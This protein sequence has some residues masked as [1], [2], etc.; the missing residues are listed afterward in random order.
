MKKTI[1]I[2]IPSLDEL[3]AQAK[4]NIKAKEEKAQ[5]FKEIA[6]KY[7]KDDL[8]DKILDQ[9]E[10]FEVVLGIIRVLCNDAS[11]GSQR[12]QMR[13]LA[14]KIWRPG[15]IGVLISKVII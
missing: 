11:T 7:H 13:E 3:D 8:V 2:E 1:D 5:A 15:V 4:S 9:W 6:K 14:K 10:Q 12:W